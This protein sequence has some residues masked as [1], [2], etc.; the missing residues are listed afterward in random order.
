MAHYNRHYRPALKGNIDIQL[1]SA[2]EDGNWALVKRLAD[3]RS[4]AAPDP[5]LEVSPSPS[6]VLHGAKEISG[7]PF[8]ISLSMDANREHA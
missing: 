2:F 3:R 1:Q 4:K 6:P 7:R 5:Y 8:T